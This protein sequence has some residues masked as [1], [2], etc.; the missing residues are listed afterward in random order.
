MVGITEVV[1]RD[2]GKDPVDGETGA[3]D[4]RGWVVPAPGRPRKVMR[5]VS[6]FSGTAAV[7][8]VVAGGGVG[9]LSESLM[10][11]KREKRKNSENSLHLAKSVPLRQSI[12]PHVLQLSAID[13]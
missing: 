1:F 12:S 10:V 9:V 5:T 7:F 8:E 13:R 2:V 4:S 3:V 11:W 6:F